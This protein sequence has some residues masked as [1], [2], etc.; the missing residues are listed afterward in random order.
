MTN[1]T[2][3][4]GDGS[5]RW[6]CPVHPPTSQAK[7]D[8]ILRALDH[9]RG[10]IDQDS[11]EPPYYTFEY[12]SRA[13]QFTREIRDE[14]AD[15]KAAVLQSRPQNIP[16]I[17]PTPTSTL[18]SGASQFRKKPVTISAIRWTG[19]NLREV[20][21]FTG[22]HPGWD[23][24]FSSWEDYERHVQQDGQQFKIFTLEGTMRADIGD[25]IIR[26]VKGGHY[27]CKPDIFEATYETSPAAAPVSAEPMAEI[28]GMD[29]YGPSLG[30]HKHWIN[31]RVGTKLYTAPVAAQPDITQQTLDDV[32][33]G[34]PA[35]DAEIDSLRK[36]IEA[37]QAAQS[38]QPVNAAD[39][40]IELEGRLL[41]VAESIMQKWQ[42]Q[43]RMPSL[44][45]DFRGFLVDGMR[46]ALA[47]QA[48]RQIQWIQ[49]PRITD[50]HDDV[51]TDR[52]KKIRAEQQAADI[53]AARKAQS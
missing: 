46:A 29:E 42:E 23:K 14:L 31:F 37:L 22:K 53:D 43:E 38:Q 40:L 25:W 4:S 6:P 2:C 16:E 5:L 28:T 7:I 51:L 17:I 30:W 13:M 1:C 36:E 44:A 3:P 33:A 21:A 35:R 47:Q 18:P 41:K 52:G 8:E 19:D 15:L 34:I 50:V 39:G 11:P 48:S 45:W 24:W 32:K 49:H 27:P 10:L 20:I 9:A 12:A 26:G